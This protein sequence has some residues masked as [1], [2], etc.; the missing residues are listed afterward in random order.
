MK[1]NLGI[2]AFLM[3]F[4]CA[5]ASAQTFCT[6]ITNSS[7][8]EQFAFQLGGARYVAVQNFITPSYACLTIDNL[9]Y[10]L[11]PQVAKVINQSTGAYA[12]MMQIN[13]VPIQ[14]SMNFIVCSSP[15]GPDTQYS[16][17]LSANSYG[18]GTP[19]QFH[20]GYLHPCAV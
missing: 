15:Q 12:E 19:I 14:P 3:L 9:S 5:C 17:N 8:G 16:F 20:R 10:I 2:A 13:Y 1:I 7:T 4:M 18:A 11:Y 6:T